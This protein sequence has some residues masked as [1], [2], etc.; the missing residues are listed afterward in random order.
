MSSWR[1]STFARAV[2]Y[3]IHTVDVPCALGSAHLQFLW[4]LRVVMASVG[5]LDS[6]VSWISAVG[7][8]VKVSF[9]PRRSI[10]RSGGQ[11]AA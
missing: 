1:N 4:F 2:E 7:R 6:A 3:A 5:H 8:A 9:F 11:L 10:P